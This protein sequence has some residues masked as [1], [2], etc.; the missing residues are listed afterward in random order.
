MEANIQIRKGLVVIF[1]LI[2]ISVAFTSSINANN[3]R[4]HLEKEFI[5][6]N[7]KANEEIKE[8]NQLDYDEDFDCL[9]FGWTT[10][11][12]FSTDGSMIAFGYVRFWHEGGSY[13]HP[14]KGRVFSYGKNGLKQWSGTFYGQ[15]STALI[16]TP[17]FADRLHIGVK[18]FSGA[19][20]KGAFYSRFIGHADHIFL[21]EEY[22]LN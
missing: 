20:I 1:I 11:T 14:A 10:N 17:L 16:W 9:I 15:I 21:G 5:I 6:G 18:G 8:Q 7:E 19:T 12:F 4:S 2:L 3:H 22:E 13:D